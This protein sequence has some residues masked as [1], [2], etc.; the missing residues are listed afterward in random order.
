MSNPKDVVQ[1]VDASNFRGESGKHMQELAT[2]LVDAISTWCY[3]HRF[4]PAEPQV[5]NNIKSLLQGL[6]NTMPEPTEFER[7]RGGDKPESEDE[8][9]PITLKN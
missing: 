1:E 7:M 3:K 8:V 4:H 2:D 6:V 9:D 5:H